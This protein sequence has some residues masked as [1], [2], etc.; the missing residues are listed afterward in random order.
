MYENMCRGFVLAL[1]ISVL[2]P[3]AAG[4]KVEP[5]ENSDKLDLLLKQNEEILEGIRALEADRE[6]QAIEDSLLRSLVE[7]G[8]GVLWRGEEGPYAVIEGNLS[9]LF[10]CYVVDR[11][12]CVGFVPT[13][14]ISRVRIKPIGI[15]LMYYQ[16]ENKPLTVQ[17]VPRRWDFM[18]TSGYDLSLWEGLDIRAQ[19]S[20]FI[21]NPG[22]VSRYVEKRLKQHHREYRQEYDDAERRIRNED[23]PYT[24]KEH[25]RELADIAERYGDAVEDDLNQFSRAYSRA[26]ESYLVLIGMR[27]RF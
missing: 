27:W 16:H 13:I 4:A 21:P 19:V 12:V 20:W 18:F 24:I 10:A 22:A 2:F 25:Y 1:S 11:G 9:Y 7:L 26:G 15:G 14:E 3:C 23:D 5:D 6:Q 8:F 17:Y